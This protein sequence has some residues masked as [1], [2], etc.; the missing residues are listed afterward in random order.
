M[1]SL[2]KKHSEIRRLIAERS[3]YDEKETVR[4]LGKF[5]RSVPASV[6]I[7][8]QNHHFDEKEVLDIGCS[9]G[10]TLLYWGEGSEGVEIKDGP[11]RF[12]EEMERKVHKLN[13][14]EGF[15]G[16]ERR[17]DGIYTNNLVEHLVSPHLFLVRL[18]GLLKPNG[19]LAIGH[20]IVPPFT[21]RGLWG[22]LGY[23]GWAS[24]EHINFFT[25][26]TAKLTL[27]RAG[28][29]VLRQYRFRRLYR[30]PVVRD[31]LGSIGINCLSICKKKKG[32]KYDKKRITEFDPAW[33]SDLKHL[34]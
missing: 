10:Q 11:T 21:F 25:A 4:L 18:H 20:P 26:Q 5:F 32:Y 27:E 17:Y 16:V 19:L 13:V 28:F 6:K 22:L 12:L 1:K 2:S 15:V 9:Y 31:I 23:K 24:V 29:Q 7:L 34:R 33:A 3:P 14:E 30:V 8:I